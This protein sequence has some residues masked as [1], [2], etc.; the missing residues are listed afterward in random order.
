MC[1][2]VSSLSSIRE[3]ELRPGETGLQENGKPLLV[4]GRRALFAMP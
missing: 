3:V 2:D 4:L 1:P